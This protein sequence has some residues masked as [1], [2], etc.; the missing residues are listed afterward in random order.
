MDS[1]PV[2]VAPEVCVD[3]RSDWLNAGA[4]SDRIA[5]R[6]LPLMAARPI[7]AVGLATLVRQL[8]PRFRHPLES[9]QHSFP[10]V[11]A[12]ASPSRSYLS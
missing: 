8:R 5:V 10:W 1:N 9:F 7:V 11:Q 12:R 2:D 4:A 6:A 3:N